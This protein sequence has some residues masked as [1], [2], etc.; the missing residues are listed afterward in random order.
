MLSL[1]RAIGSAL[2]LKIIDNTSITPKPVPIPGL[3]TLTSTTA[4]PLK[5]IELPS[6]AAPSPPAQRDTLNPVANPNVDLKTI[7]VSVASLP[8][9]L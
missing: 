3:P 2:E 1:P 9:S 7:V 6:E 8:A 5:L 4:T